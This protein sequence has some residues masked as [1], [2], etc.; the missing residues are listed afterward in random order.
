MKPII[1]SIDQSIRSTAFCID[2]EVETINTKP[3]DH[4]CKRIDIIFNRLKEVIDERKPNIISIEQYAFNMRNTR[5]LSVLMELGGVLKRLFY[6]YGY[7]PIVISPKTWKKMVFGNHAMKKDLILLETYKLFNAPCKN[8][9]EADAYCMYKFVSYIYKYFH[10]E[11]F[12]NKIHQEVFEQYVYNALKNL[13]KKEFKENRIGSYNGLKR[14]MKEDEMIEVA[15]EH[16]I[17]NYYKEL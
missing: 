4:T 6:Q 11:E 9:D 13:N 10:R 8:S 1:L 17:S 3:K 16:F 5:S 7:E 14:H 12:E 2:G 15:K